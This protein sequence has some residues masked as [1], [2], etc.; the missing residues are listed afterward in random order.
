MASQKK[1]LVVARNNATKVEIAR[2]R[3]K[4]EPL[5]KRPIIKEVHEEPAKALADLGRRRSPPQSRIQ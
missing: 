1:Y 3:P 5:V 2:N 4:R